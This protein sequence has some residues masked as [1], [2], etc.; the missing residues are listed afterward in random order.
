MASISAAVAGVATLAALC[1]FLWRWPKAATVLLLVLTVIAQTLQTV[2]SSTAGNVDEAAVV[3]ALVVFT[4]RR[5]VKQGNIRWAP[6]FWFFGIYFFLGVISAL[7]NAVPVTTWALGAFLVLK[8]PLLLLGVMQVNWEPQ[9]I[10]RVIRVGVALL[11]AVLFSAVINAVIPE[12]WNSV[13]GRQ[14]V[15]Y[16]MGVPSLTGIFDHPVGLGSTMGMAFL[17]V[18]AYHRIV[19]RT[20]LS[21][22]LLCATAF[23]GILTFRRKSIAAAVLMAMFGRLALPGRKAVAV[24][25]LVLAV[26]V[27]LLLGWDSLDRLVST[28]YDEYFTNVDATARTLM[29][30][31]SIKLAFAAFPLGVGFGRYGSAVA[32]SEYS[33]LYDSMGY[34]RIYGMGPGERGG[35]LTDTFWPSLIAETG[36]IGAL[37]Y[38]VGILVVVV[39]SWRLMRRAKN[40]YEQW[41]GATVVAWMGQLLIESLAAP[42]F[43]GPPMFGPVFMLAGVAVAV[44]LSQQSS[45][46][47]LNLPP[48]WENI[49]SSTTH[50]PVN[51]MQSVS[52]SAPRHEDSLVYTVLEPSEST[53]DFTGARAAGGSPIWGA[54]VEEIEEG[55]R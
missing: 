41:L 35:F 34:T 55:N 4:V 39:P 27:A 47:V 53:D 18:L 40:R 20:A 23:A 15:S 16:R 25:L 51:V 11:L 48:T 7:V 5:L 31:D 36:F 2:V 21:W 29:T 17:A 43:T 8:G 46:N 32:A 10:P 50:E 1:A 13:V 49:A 12:A 45:T 44:N 33:P 14:S 37:C 52:E 9:D 6:A 26:P 54:S 24:V 38:L 30:I 22:A 28:T 19:A 42:V 3:L